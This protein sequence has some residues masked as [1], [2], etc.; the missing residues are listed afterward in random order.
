ML[1][2]F[3]LGI[4][5]SLSISCIAQEGNNWTF[6]NGFGMDFGK[7]P[8]SMLFNTGFTAKSKSSLSSQSVSNC[9]GELLLY[10]S[11]TH[12]WNGKHQHLK[13][14]IKLNGTYI[15]LIIPKPGDDSSFYYFHSN[16]TAFCYNV[17]LRWDSGSGNIDTI[18]FWRPDSAGSSCAAFTKHAN[19]TDYWLLIK[20][21]MLE[22]W[23]YLVT[24][25]GI[26]KK[27]IKSTMWGS[28]GSSTMRFS[29]NGKMV[30]APETGGGLPPW[31]TSKVYIYDFDNKTG[32]CSNQRH[33]ISFTAVYPFYPKAAYG[34]SFS[35][36]DSLLYGQY[37]TKNAHYILQ[38]KGYDSLIAQTCDTV[39]K[40]LKYGYYSYGIQLAANNKMYFWADSIYSAQSNQLSTIEY[41]DVKG[42]SCKVKM[43]SYS[44]APYG[45]NYF[46]GIVFPCYNFPVKRIAN[47]FNV[48]GA[49]GCGYDT[50]RFT[51]DGDSAFTYFRWYFG[52]GDSA[53]G[54]SVLHQYA[55]PGSYYVRLACTLGPCGYRQWVG[56]S[57]HIKFKPNVSIVPTSTYTCGKNEL[58][59]AISYR[60]ADTLHFVTLNSFQGLPTSGSSID[61]TFV[62]INSPTASSFNQ[63]FTWQLTG[64]DTFAVKVSNSQCSDSIGYIHSVKIDP[65]A[66]ASFQT[67]NPASCGSST[68]TFS[69]TSHLDSI[70]AKRAWHIKQ[71]LKPVQGDAYDSILY[72]SQNQLN[73]TLT[74]TG[75]Y[76]VTLTQTTRQGCVDS[77][78]K[79]DFVWVHPL[80]EP[81][82]WVDGK[83]VNGVKWVNV[84]FGD[85]ALLSVIPANAGILRY[86]WS[87]SDTS[88]SITVTKPGTISVKVWDDWNC[89]ATSEPVQLKW[90]PELKVTLYKTTDS[91]LAKPNRAVTTYKWYRNSKQVAVGNMQYLYHADSG[92]YQIIVTDSNGCTATSN[93]QKFYW[94]GIT[95]SPVERAGVRL[96]PNPANT[97]L[98]VTLS[99]V[100]GLS[101]YNHTILLTDLAGKQ[102]LT[103]QSKN[104]STITLNIAHLANGIYFI[105]AAGQHL[106]FIKQ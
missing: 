8:D 51:F 62:V 45:L 91:L 52:D 86:L 18:P 68:F 92:T 70:V 23:A 24:K 22:V 28:Y 61:T 94:T 71:T 101:S 98:Y 21:N 79:P 77:L 84:C 20:T 34:F 80:P 29:N 33:L 72:T 97:V 87:T 74:D 56:D 19:D 4:Y 17:N 76:T 40:E 31:N 16:G 85:T 58:T 82:V 26:A 57:V 99:E 96:F 35:P 43:K 15:C 83:M 38:Y 39:S 69:D 95:P 1:R 105:E 53:D 106:K 7:H 104:E 89:Y 12:L 3:S 6:G 46:F 2:L 41:P 25:N 78:A 11:G 42:I 10:S 102:V 48:S 60:Y 55:Q 75:K 90:L 47:K 9:N 103:T 67:N 13:D 59:L 37:V 93:Y 63:T 44:V 30:V 27:P 36:N 66:A 65:P 81:V 14:T 54:R 73:I 100:E 49:D 5:L 88:K 64:M 50:A 32:K